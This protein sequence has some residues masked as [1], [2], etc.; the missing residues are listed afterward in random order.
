MALVL[1]R[2]LLHTR[3]IS[4]PCLRFSRP[5]FRFLSSSK[6][7]S[8]SGEADHEEFYHYTSGRWLWDEEGRLAERY[9]WFNVE[10]LKK[11]AVASVAARQCVS[12]VKLAEGAS[13]KVFRLGMDNGSVVIGRIPNPSTGQL[14]LTLASEVATMDF[15]SWLSRTSYA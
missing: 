1:R 15:V 8:K 5:R 12:M 10:E 13:N 11:I 14:G 9:R 4:Y 2:W 3:V 7:S 6:L